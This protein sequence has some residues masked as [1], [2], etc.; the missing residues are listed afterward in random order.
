MQ[1]H[2]PL[3]KIS[4]NVEEEVW[5]KF[6]DALPKNYIPPSILFVGDNGYATL[7]LLAKAS[8]PKSIIM[9]ADRS[10]ETIKRLGRITEPKWILLPGDVTEQAM[11]DTI[12]KVTPGGVYAVFMKHGVYMNSSKNQEK[13]VAE[14]FRLTQPGGVVGWSAPAAA[15]IF[16]PRSVR[17]F[18]DKS[19]GHDLRFSTV[20]IGINTPQRHERAM[21][22]LI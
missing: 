18:T 5:K 22:S 11:V 6:T 17:S 14:L 13:L 19:I 2:N 1:E 3:E 16:M 21:Q 15:D 10:P 8:Y 9:I 20:Y 12:D 7:P 4:L